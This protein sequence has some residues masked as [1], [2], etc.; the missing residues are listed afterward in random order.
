MANIPQFEYNSITVSLTTPL[1]KDDPYVKISKRKDSFSQSGVRQ[2]AYNYTEN[3]KLLEMGFLTGTEKDNM[4]TMF[5]DWADEGKTIKFIP[6]N[7]A[8]AVYDTVTIVDKS[9]T[10]EREM[11]GVDYWRIKFKIRKEV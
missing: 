3:V 8:T 5:D 10:F 4:I 1:T 7:T 9:F 11:P 2:A 6:D